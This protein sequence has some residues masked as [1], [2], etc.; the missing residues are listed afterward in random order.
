MMTAR[1]ESPTTPSPSTSPGQAGT[2]LTADGLRH[3]ERSIAGNYDAYFRAIWAQTLILRADSGSIWFADQLIQQMLDARH[4]HDAVAWCD[5][6]PQL[7]VGQLRGAQGRATEGD[8]ALQC[9]A[10]ILAS[11]GDLAHPNLQT[12]NDLQDR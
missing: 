9:A 5:G 8:A 3:D 2:K 11:A 7:V 6:Y 10:D 12:V 1:S 4:G